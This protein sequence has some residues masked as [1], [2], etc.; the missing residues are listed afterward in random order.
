ITTGLMV[1]PPARG[2]PSFEQYEREKN[3]I[4]ASLKRRALKMVAAFNAMEGVTCNNADGAM[5]LFPQI[6][7][8][9]KAVQAAGSMPA[10]EFYCMKMVEETGVVTVPGSGF[11]QVDG[12]YH[13]RTTFLP[14]EDQIDEVIKRLAD[15]H[16]RFMQTYK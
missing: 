16:A 13:F 10:D 7:L 12:T 11:G 9:A 3:E 14:P 15:F 2:E 6:R 4:L 8:P 1:R 5:Y